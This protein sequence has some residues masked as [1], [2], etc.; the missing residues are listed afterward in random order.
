MKAQRLHPWIPAFVLAGSLLTQ[1]A[2]A[3]PPFT[4]VPIAGLPGIYLGSVA[5]ADYDGDGRLDFLITGITTNNMMTCQLWRNTGSGFTNVPI[6]GLKGLFHSSVAWGDYLNEGLPGF[7]ITGATNNAYVDPSVIQ[8]WRYN[9]TGFVQ[10]VTFGLPPLRNGAVAW[11]DYDNDGR[12]DLLIMGDYLGIYPITQLWRNTGGGFIQVPVPGLPQLEDGSVAWADFDNVGR[13]GFLITGS[14]FQGGGSGGLSQLWRNTGSGFTNVPIPGLPNLF[15]SSVAWGDF[16]NDGRL[17]FL[18]T[19]TPDGSTGISQLWRNTGSGFTNV[20][21]PGL[22]GVYKGSVAWGD[23][24]NDGRLDFLICGIDSSGN[25]I[26]QLWRNTGSGFT[27]VPIPGLPGVGNGAVAWGDYDNDGRLDFLIM[28][29]PTNITTH[30]ICELWRNT[31]LSASNAPPNAPTGLSETFVDGGT[32]ALQWTPPADDVTPSAGLSYAVRIGTTPG[33]SDILAPPALADGTRLLPQMGPARG[34]SPFLFHFLVGA[35]YY[36]SVQAVDTSFAGSAFSTNDQFTI[37]VGLAPPGHILV[38]P[39]DTNGDG[40][41]DLNELNAVLENYNHGAVDQSA[42][43]LVLT[44]YWSYNP[45]RITNATGLGSPNVVFKL[46]NTGVDPF[47][48]ESSTDLVNW[49]ILGPAWPSFQ[50][51][52]TNAPGQPRRFYRL[53][54]P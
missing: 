22:P 10:D 25:Y 3:D 26:S 43:N 41:V 53:R 7:L 20:A 35:T 11:G 23:Y 8:L 36:W 34:G 44:N 6:P 18:I 45:F 47:T 37:G 50:V 15:D 9:G 16:D 17:G 40:V 46:N 28:G 33:G 4:N 49:S 14:V 2:I 29:S 24:D 30:L 5:W 51:T 13:P 12:L 52:D 1:L 39:G 31:T 21:I 19:G 27:N 38:V 32:M 54:W 42:L 48:T